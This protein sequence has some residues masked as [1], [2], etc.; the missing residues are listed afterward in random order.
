MNVDIGEPLSP[1]EDPPI[2]EHCYDFPL[3]VLHATGGICPRYNGGICRPMPTP[4]RPYNMEEARAVILYAD[5]LENGIYG[6]IIEASGTTI[7][8]GEEGNA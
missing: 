2:I 1:F 4:V 8:P 6:K 5:A 3:L 7:G